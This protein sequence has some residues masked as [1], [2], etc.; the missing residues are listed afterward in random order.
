MIERIKSYFSHMDSARAL[1]FLGGGFAIVLAALIGLGAVHAYDARQEREQN[2]WLLAADILRMR[3]ASDEEKLYAELIRGR[4]GTVLSERDSR[5]FSAMLREESAGEML[6]NA[7]DGIES[8]IEAGDFSAKQLRRIL[9]DVL[10]EAEAGQP[11]SAASKSTETADVPSLSFLPR[12][13]PVQIA[14]RFFGVHDLFRSALAA[15]ETHT[16][17]YC[18]NVY[19]VFDQKT[20]LMTQYVAECVPGKPI[21]SDGECVRAA[22]AYAR[23]RQGMDEMT[24]GD[25]VA[26]RGIYFVHLTGK[27]TTGAWIGV[28]Q[29]TG[30][31]CFFLRSMGK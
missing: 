8:A 21:L 11:L 3:D 18:E 7:G 28:R 30:R 13:D 20:G 25:A 19:A 26:S 22:M 1:R 14:D 15:G 17:A 27:D 12:V 9:T 5:A 29:D 10:R 2:A 24:P 4:I 6:H 16:V 23:D 31:I